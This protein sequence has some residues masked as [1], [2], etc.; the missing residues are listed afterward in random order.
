MR[1]IFS[2]PIHLDFFQLF[3]LNIGVQ[4]DVN[5]IADTSCFD[6]NEGRGLKSDYTFNIGYHFMCLVL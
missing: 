3:D 6:N 1:P 2:C 5:V 4:T